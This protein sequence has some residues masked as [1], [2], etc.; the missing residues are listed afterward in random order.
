V[1]DY[2]RRHLCADCNE[3]DPGVLEFDHIGDKLASI[4]ALVGDTATKR[5]LE[6]EMARCEVVCA[7]CHRRRTARRSRWR[8]AQADRE[9]MRAI[10]DPRVARNVAHIHAILRR[11]ACVDCGE[12][13]PI[14][15]EFDHV[16]P[17]RGSVTQL[18]W[19]GYSLPTI[20][21]EIAQCEIR[22]ANCHRRATAARRGHFRS[23]VLS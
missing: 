22:C 19:W 9:P 6:L 14:V 8:R 7:N 20:D 23:R 16:G 12:R 17:K 13:E 18:G 15:L 10:I 5:A 2:L 3:A 21:A 4:S 11:S 1:L